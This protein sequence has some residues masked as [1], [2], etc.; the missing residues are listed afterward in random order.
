M[1][2][3][4][5]KNVA[6]LIESSRSY[7]RSLLRGVAQFARTQGNWSLLHEEMTIDADLPTWLAGAQPD[8][9][10]ARLDDHIIQPLR[11]LQIPIVDV[12][13]RRNYADIPQVETDDRAVARM[14]FEHLWQR[15]FRRFAFCG[16][17][18][19]HFSEIRLASFREMVAAEE[20]PLS[21]YETDGAPEATLT[22]I[23]RSGV[24][25]VAPLSEWLAGL[26]APTGLFVC[27]D[28]RGQQALNACR[29]LGIS[30][31]DDLGVIG[32]DDDDAI[33]PLSDPPLS[34][35]RPNADQ[36]GYRAAE[37][38]AELMHGATARAGIE[39]IAPTGI[40]QRLSTQVMAVEDREVA[41][42]CQFIRENA[43]HG[44]DVGD[45]V[46]KT[47]L[48]RR[49]LERRFRSALKRTPREEITAVQI[50]RVK[51][52]LTETEMSLEQLAPLA[53]YD[54]KESLSAIFKRETGQTPGQFRR[55]VREHD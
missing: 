16:Y 31:P 11:Q 2:P 42:A 13:C 25:D 52:L 21:V 46:R 20:C 37:T 39:Y 22:S 19:A 4:N 53:G 36:I 1:P 44:I 43:G 5:R 14:V 47:S 6:L 51:Q 10:I 29:K 3:R 24:V 23:E 26:Q 38:L 27:N 32:V 30:V 49:Q 15:G 41:R 28:I 12:R 8:G 18:G 55:Y 35:V 17:R 40:A 54:Y 7:G 9:V 33:C 34:S 45:V 50:A 48:S